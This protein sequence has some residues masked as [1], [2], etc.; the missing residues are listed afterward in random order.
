MLGLLVALGGGMLVGLERERRK[1]QGTPGS[2]AG[3]RTFAVVA[4]SGALAQLLPSAGLVLIG[5]GFVAVLCTASYLKS[6]SR[7]LGLTTEAALFATYLIGVA[8]IVAPLLSAACAVGLA[9]LLAARTGLHRF[10]TQVLS[11]QELHDALLLAGLALV[12]LP[13]VPSEPLPWIGGISARPL[14]LLVLLLLSLQA[15][16]H[17]ALRWLGPQAGSAVAGFLAGFASSS[18]AIATLGTRARREPAQ[19]R[20]LATGAAL[21]TAATWVLMPVIAAALS[22]PAA[23]VILPVALAG[24]GASLAVGFVLAVAAR[25]E[26]RQDDSGTPRRTSPLS[27][28]EALIVAAGLTAISLVMTEANRRFGS[29]GV[30]TSAALAGLADAHA[31]VAPLSALFGSGQLSAGNFEI[32]VML[33]I[34]L[35]SLSRGV[36]AFVAGGPRYAWRVGTALLAGNASAWAA[37]FLLPTASP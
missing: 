25:G 18:A 31:P 8:A 28:R 1:G 2:M 9:G 19:T 3:L 21:S 36:I 32:G 11:E 17:V 26:A 13:L 24:A 27:L 37:L 6:R 23:G 16:A 12:V 30:F 22:P 20:L 14:A 35:N 29:G 4:F 5:A 7:D 34:S 33:A 10:A 15:L